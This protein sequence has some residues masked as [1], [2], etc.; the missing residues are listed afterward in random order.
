MEIE[1][2]GVP[3]QRES[4]TG[5][6]PDDVLSALEDEL[7][8]SQ[9]KELEKLMAE[10][11]KETRETNIYGFLNKLGSDSAMKILSKILTSLKIE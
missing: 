1:T 8:I 11:N 7:T 2:I 4:D 9:F 6:K 5:Q 3:E 10:S